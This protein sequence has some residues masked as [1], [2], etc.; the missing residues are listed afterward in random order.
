MPRPVT[1]SVLYD[2]GALPYAVLTAQ[3]AWRDHGGRL[4]ELAGVGSGDH[5]L[6]AGCGPGE[7]AF[8]MAERVP[9]LRITGV[10]CSQAMIAVARRRRRRDP[11]GPAVEFL[12]GDATR[13]PFAD[14]SFDAVTGQSFLYLLPDAAEVLAE[15][16]R[17]LRPTRRCVFL[18]PA[19]TAQAAFPEALRA[20]A[21]REP[22]FVSS[23][24]LWRMF[25]RRFGRFDEARLASL[26]AG[27]GL[28]TIDIAPTLS[29]LGLIG[30]AERGP[31]ASLSDVDWD[32]WVPT[33]RATL[34]FVVEGN[35]I[36]LIRKK[37]GLGAGKINGPGGRIEPG[38]S[39][40][41]C[42]IR[43]VQEELCVTPVGVEDAGELAFQFADGYA[44]HARVFRASGCVGVPVETEEATPLFTPI[45]RIPFAE[46]WADDALWIPLMLARKRF[47]GRF[48]F[49]GDRMLDHALVGPEGDAIRYPEASE[50]TTPSRR[51]P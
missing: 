41:A 28:R 43:E 36:L 21:L 27:A 22:R 1:R 26:F 33:D 29:G 23:M 3:P 31:I 32:R 8:G 10:D 44:L 42:A 37:R 49:D 5:L 13:L 25:S 9:G 24:W 51:R 2:L 48:V 38:E 47:S 12:H 30:V 19:V 14:A 11:S 4:A 39:A 34:L 7:G 6:D 40:R 50:C 18:E 35:R 46:M 17:V 15:L 45:D 16:S 20:R